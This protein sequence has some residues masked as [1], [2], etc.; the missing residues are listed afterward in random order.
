MATRVPQP[1]TP[2]PQTR[3]L[4]RHS[5]LRTKIEGS[6]EKPRPAFSQGHSS[7][8]GNKENRTTSCRAYRPKTLEN[9]AHLPDKR[10][11]HDACL[12]EMGSGRTLNSCSPL[13]KVQGRHGSG[14]RALELSRD[15]ERQAPTSIR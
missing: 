10:P 7:R 1:R 9:L 13:S 15:K 4:S 12:G 6:T 14:S 11:G 5:R 3:A 8:R 2:G